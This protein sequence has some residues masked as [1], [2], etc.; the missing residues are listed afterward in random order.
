MVDPRLGEINPAAFAAENALA[1]QD[2]AARHAKQSA[3]PVPTAVQ[4]LLVQKLFQQL[5]PNGGISA[6]AA[7]VLAHVIVDLQERI[8]ALEAAQP[9]AGK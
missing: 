9:Q 1:V 3:K 7:S 2:L 4:N 8:A 6:A 5:G